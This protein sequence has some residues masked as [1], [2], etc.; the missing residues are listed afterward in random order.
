MLAKAWS[1]L[2]LLVQ[3][4]PLSAVVVSQLCYHETSYSQFSIPVQAEAGEAHGPAPRGDGEPAVGQGQDRSRGRLL[5]LCSEDG[6]LNS[7]RTTSIIWEDCSSNIKAPASEHEQPFDILIHK[8]VCICDPGLRNVNDV[9]G[10]QLNV[11]YCGF[12]VDRLFEVHAD[13]NGRVL[14]SF[15]RL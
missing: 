9:K 2:H 1:C 14:R 13:R 6:G 11:S 5:A 8:Q 15:R 10:L 12:S 3:L 7:T 4:F